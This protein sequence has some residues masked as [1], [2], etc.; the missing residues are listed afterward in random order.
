[1]G[2][3]TRNVS[4]TFGF[5]I[6]TLPHANCQLHLWDIGG[7]RGIRAYWRNYFEETDGLVFVIDAAAP[8]RFEEA[9]GELTVL[10]GQ[11]RLANASV[12][13]L[14]NKQDCPEAVAAEEIRK[15][16]GLDAVLGGDGRTHWKLLGCSAIAGENVDEGLN[17]L[18]NDICTRLYHHRPVSRMTA[19]VNMDR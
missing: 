17:W 5:R 8:W 3:S 13:L 2:A 18:V 19:D 7:Q 11:D 10:L 16:L 15:G 1:M 6:H 4:P 9:L 14:A 12:L